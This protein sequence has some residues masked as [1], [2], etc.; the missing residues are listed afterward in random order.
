MGREGKDGEGG[1]GWGGFGDGG[2]HSVPFI[3]I[4]RLVSP[5]RL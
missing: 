4:A 2:R 5:F 3:L 1:E